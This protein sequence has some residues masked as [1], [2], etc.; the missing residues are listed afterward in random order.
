MITNENVYNI[1]KKAIKR[2]I[3]I[4]SINGISKTVCP[5]KCTV[6]FTLHVTGNYDYRFLS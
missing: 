3:S 2:V 4:L 5:S 6:E 1:H